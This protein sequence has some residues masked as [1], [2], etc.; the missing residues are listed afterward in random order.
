VNWQLGLVSADDLA[1]QIKDQLRS[2]FNERGWPVTL[3]DQDRANEVEQPGDGEEALPQRPALFRAFVAAL[4]RYC[5]WRSRSMGFHARRSPAR[6]TCA[7][8]EV[9]AAISR[10]SL[11]IGDSRLAQ[12]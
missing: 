9:G 5:V 10:L 4:T 3:A 2:L 6:S 12:P 8:S 7:G 11:C 1:A